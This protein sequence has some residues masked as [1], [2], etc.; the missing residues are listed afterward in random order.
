MDLHPYDTIHH[1]TTR[2][3]ILLFARYLHITYLR[4]NLQPITYLLR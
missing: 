2:H 4:N 1:D 3:D